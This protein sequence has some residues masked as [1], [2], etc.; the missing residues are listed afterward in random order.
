ML[1]VL[2]CLPALVACPSGSSSAGG[3]VKTAG[4]AGTKGASGGSTSTATDAGTAD[5]SY[6][7]CADLHKYQS[8]TQAWIDDV[9][10]QV[11]I[12]KLEAGICFNANADFGND[13]TN[14]NTACWMFARRSCTLPT[15][16]QQPHYDDLV[17]CARG[18]LVPDT[19]PNCQT[20]GVIADSVAAACKAR[21][22]NFVQ[23]CNDYHHE[24]FACP[25]DICK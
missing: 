17:S 24:S 8:N 4:T 1:V 15:P 11:G 22:K 6:P 9:S 5:T 23:W 7:D 20:P 2:A 12:T 10:T 19:C 16:C 13:G 3:P 14:G 18:T 25:N 21:V